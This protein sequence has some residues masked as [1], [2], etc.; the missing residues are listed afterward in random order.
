M[1]RQLVRDGRDANRLSRVVL[2]PTV[3]VLACMAGGPLW[4][5]SDPSETM[6]RRQQGILTGMPFMANVAPRT[7]VDDLGRKIY[8]AKVPKRIVSLAPSITEM[9]FAIGAG[10]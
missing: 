6:K 10:E 5:A 4:G 1:F 7:F 8:L 2:L 9:L 3:V